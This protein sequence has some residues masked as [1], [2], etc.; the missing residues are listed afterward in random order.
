MMKWYYQHLALSPLSFHGTPFVISLP[1]LS[2]TPKA[3]YDSMVLEC[4]GSLIAPIASV[5]GGEAFLP[6]LGPLL[7]SLIGRLVCLYPITHYHCL[8]ATIYCVVFFFFR[9]LQL[10]SFNELPWIHGCVPFLIAFLVHR[11]QEIPL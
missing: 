5:I 9:D 2:I 4:A 7:P 3:E 8:L 10:R 1:C 11:S 6:W